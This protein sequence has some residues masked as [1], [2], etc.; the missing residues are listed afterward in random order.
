MGFRVV[1]D[2]GNSKIEIHLDTCATFQNSSESS[3]TK[4]HDVNMISDAEQT[5]KQLG[6]RFNKEWKKADCCMKFF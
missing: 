3:T 6:K 5:A 1:E 4:W 2:S